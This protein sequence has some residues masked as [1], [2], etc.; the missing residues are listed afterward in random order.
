VKGSAT[1]NGNQTASQKC[2]VLLNNL[3]T[4]S[5]NVNNKEN[6]EL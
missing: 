5:K 6:A 1:G 2:A 3:F 4:L